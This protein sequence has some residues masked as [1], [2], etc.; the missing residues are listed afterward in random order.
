MTKNTQRT[1]IVRWAE[2]TTKLDNL[3][4]SF[5]PNILV[6]QLN[7]LDLLITYSIIFIGKTIV[8]NWK[9]FRYRISEV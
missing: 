7:L 8:L 5:I 6:F 9:I 2:T 4:N 3:I 1:F